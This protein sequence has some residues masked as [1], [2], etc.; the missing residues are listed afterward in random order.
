VPNCSLAETDEYYSDKKCGLYGHCGSKISPKHEFSIMHNGAPAY[1][2]TDGVGFEDNVLFVAMEGSSECGTGNCGT[3]QVLDVDSGDWYTL[4]HLS[5]GVVEM[6][7]TVSTGETD[8][9][10]TV[11]EDYGVGSA[12]SMGMPDYECGS[13]WNFW[14]G[15]KDKMSSHFLDR[16]GL[17]PNQGRLYRFVA[18]SGETDM[19]TFVDWPASG[20]PGYEFTDKMGRL[21]PIDM[22][23]NGVYKETDT[24]KGWN[25]TSTNCANTISGATPIRMTGR[26]KQEWGA[27]NPDKPNQFAIAETGLG[28][29]STIIDYMEENIAMGKRASTLIFLEHDFLSATMDFASRNGSPLPSSI[30]CKVF[31]VMKDQVVMG[32][33]RTEGMSY[34]DSL[35]WATGGNVYFAEDSSAPGGYNIGGVYN[36]ETEKTIPLVGAIG[37]ANKKMNV[38]ANFPYGSFHGRSS[39]E[40]TGW[41][42]ASAVLTVPAGATP[43]QFHDALTAKEMMLDNQMKGVGNGCM[44]YGFYYSSQMMFIE[45]P[46][47]DWATTALYSPPAC[48]ADRRRKLSKQFPKKR[49]LRGETA[50]CDE[51]NDW[52]DGHE[53]WHPDANGCQS[54]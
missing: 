9:T 1:G 28:Y 51:I 54:H 29:S 8:Y 40:T 34:V 17:G 33:D 37:S 50:T 10:I 27:A 19:A 46:E 30:P 44:H 41:F 12:S 7:F 4:P 35:F 38:V 32:P 21:E 48:D 26:S 5:M 45:V 39:Q 22:V 14:V 49:A 6:A 16:N 24:S 15:K 20:F 11:I 2:A 47:F 36:I 31:H 42:D 43:Q 23:L 3:V 52:S 13:G 18:D 25:R 53:D